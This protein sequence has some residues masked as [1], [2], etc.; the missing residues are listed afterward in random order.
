MNHRRPL[1]RQR[2]STIEPPVSEDEELIRLRT[3]LT[4]KHQQLM[5]L[6]EVIYN[7]DRVILYT[8]LGISGHRAK[9]NTH[10]KQAI[11]TMINQLQFQLS[12]TVNSI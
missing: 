1:K 7:N 3:K 9:L 11:E 12:E 8:L 4:Q 2:M 6:R 5:E 10:K